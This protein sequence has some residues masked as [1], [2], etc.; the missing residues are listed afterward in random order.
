MWIL[1]LI[2]S[3]GPLG[4]A[5]KQCTDNG[6][7]FFNANTQSVWTNYT[8]CLPKNVTHPTHGDEL[9]Q[10]LIVSPM[11]DRLIRC[12][13]F[14]DTQRYIRSLAFW[15]IVL[16]IS[17]KKLSFDNYNKTLFSNRVDFKEPWKWRKSE[18]TTSIVIKFL[19]TMS[20]SDPKVLLF[21]PYYLYVPQIL[22]L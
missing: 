16:L 21:K 17:V 11:I 5:Y 22:K 9:S 7:W 3:L 6:T 18:I 20:L 10:I 2:E 8:N 13:V 12:H 4:T 15:R 1:K 19:R 14:S